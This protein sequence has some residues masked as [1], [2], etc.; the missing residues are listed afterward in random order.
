[1]S[2]TSSILDT[3]PALYRD[4]GTELHM[5]PDFTS[6]WNT[7]LQGHKWWVLMPPEVLPDAFLCDSGCSA[8]DTDITVLSWYTHVLPQLRNRWG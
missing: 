1:L 8:K 5:D 4:T 6:P 7:V 3:F 2:A